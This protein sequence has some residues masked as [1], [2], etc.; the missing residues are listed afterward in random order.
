P[1]GEPGFQERFGALLRGYR[2]ICS[3]SSELI[4]HIPIFMAA[5]A[6]SLMLW[7][8]ATSH[9]DLVQTQWKARVQPLLDADADQFPT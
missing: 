6:T 1:W 2:E 3:L 7:G 4:V 8:A 5:R 9:E